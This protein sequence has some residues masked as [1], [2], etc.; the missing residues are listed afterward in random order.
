MARYLFGRL[1]Q[2]PVVL[3]VVLTIVFVVLRL[4]PGSPVDLA[5]ESIRDPRE[6]ERIRREWGLDEPIHRQYVD[7]L[8]SM[9]RGNFGRSFTTNTPIS[10]VIIERYPATLELAL[11]SLLIGLAV[12]VV[13]GVVAAVRQGTLVDLLVRSLALIGISVPSFWLG[14]MMIGVFAVQWGWLPVGGRFNPRIPFEPITNFYVLDALLLGE[15]R[16]ALVALSHM[17]MPAIAMGLFVAGFIVRIV[18][19]SVA[20]ALIQDYIKTARAKGLTAR[21][22][23]GG[24]AMRNA[25]MPIITILGLQFG[26]LLGGSAVIETV[27]SYPGIG[28]LMIDAIYWRDYTLIQASVLLIA[29][30]YIVINFVVDVLYSL[31][32]PRVRYS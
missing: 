20:E 5:T 11:L 6:V 29:A 14:L 4:G 15:P 23:T 26:A 31:V 10:N 12:G 19:A 8:A 22:I 2:L 13:G 1:L 17:V 3:L 21:A 27:F 18:R 7:Y 25:L 32:D 24:H 28:K 16:L 30:T 9:V